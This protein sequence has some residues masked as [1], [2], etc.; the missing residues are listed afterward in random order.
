MAGQAKVAETQFK[1]EFTVDND[2][3]DIGDALTTNFTTL[4]I[5]NS[6]RSIWPI[7]QLYF[8]IDNQ[9]FIENNIYGVDT[10]TCKIYLTGDTGDESSEPVEFK[11]LYL[12]AK[13][14]LPPKLEK[15][16]PMDD[17]KENQRRHVI[18]TCL[19]LP[20]YLA[21]TSFVNKLY[22]EPTNMTPLDIVKDLLD[23]KKIDKTKII[24]KGA[25]KNFISQMIIPP[26]TIR[27]AVDYIH[28][29]YGIYSGP[30]FRYCNYSGQ[31]L[32]WDLKK[33][34]DK[35]KENPWF[36]VHKIPSAFDTPGTMDEINDQTIS[37]KDEFMIYDVTETIH[38]ANAG[39]IRYGYDNI[40]IYHPHE[41]IA[42]FQKKN[43]EDIVQDYGIWQ[44]DK[45]MK[46]HKDLKARK[47]YFNDMVGFE[48]NGYDGE[49][50]NSILIND[51]AT[52]FQNESAVRIVVYRNVKFTKL[53]KVG[54][55]MYLKP[56]S[57][58]ELFKGSNYEGG[59]LVSDS[60]IVLTREQGGSQQNNINCIATLTAYRT[61]QSKDDK[62]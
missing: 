24:D 39:I 51:M 58:F 12:E 56:Y 57:D 1:V 20:A 62:N 49:Y 30:M 19:S 9:V 4:R 21:M 28:Q 29:N 11:L 7:F 25:N 33:K 36:K 53:I 18:M 59:Y 22:E 13:L 38:H 61:V 47:M 16:S 15:N 10:L 6:T 32:L 46:Y 48:K 55:V 54:E 8:Q 5:I 41:D 44:D 26:M 34:F 35:E 43:V 40:Y 60:D 17:A 3:G 45:K 27:S 2:S 50:D 37:T 42:V 23:Q 14:D 52:N 31:F